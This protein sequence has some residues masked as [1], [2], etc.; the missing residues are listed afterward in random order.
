MKRW[1]N[2]LAWL[3]LMPF[4][5]LVVVGCGTNTAPNTTPSDVTVKHVSVKTVDEKTTVKHMRMRSVKTSVAPMTV[6]KEQGDIN[7]PILELHNS[8]YIPN[9]PY[10]AAP[11]QFAAEMEWLHSHDFHSITFDELWDAIEHGTKLPS[12]PIIISFD[13]GHE[14]N[15][16]MATPILKQY[17]FVAT[18]FMISGAI[19]KPGELTKQDLVAMENSGTWEIESHSV[20][21]PYL[22]KLSLAQITYE[23]TQ[24][25]KTLESVVGHPVDYFC[26]P[27]GDYNNTVIEAVHNAGYRLATTVH[28]GYANP[29]QQ[30]PLTLK[31]IACHEDLT[32]AEFAQRLSPSLQQPT[33]SP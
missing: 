1:R 12:R 17:G 20:T 3:T 29:Y 14:S 18:E 19:G 10:A 21:H 15:Y 6:S 33:T 13:D 8:A 28:Q 16:T 27:Y 7:V 4:A 26:Y 31:R 23:V 32:L 30:G 24:S 22:S 2:R 5:G 9:W 25:K 11:G